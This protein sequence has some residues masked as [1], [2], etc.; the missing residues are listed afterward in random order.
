MSHG[1]RGEREHLDFIRR[2][3]KQNGSRQW[4]TGRAN[5]TRMR[6]EFLGRSQR[7]QGGCESPIFRSRMPHGL[8]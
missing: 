1:K 2:E 4:R 8:G 7:L 3:F 6:I 5:N